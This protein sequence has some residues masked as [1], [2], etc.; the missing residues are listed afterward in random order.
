ML[1]PRLAH[2]DRHIR[3][4]ARVALERM[5]LAVWQA[6]VLAADDPDC[7]IGGV[8]ALAHTADSPAQRTCSRRSIGSITASSRCGSNWIICGHCR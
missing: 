4:A 1:V 7:V 8:V 2:P 3:Y 5:P 6:R